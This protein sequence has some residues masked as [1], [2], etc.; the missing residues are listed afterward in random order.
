MS[1][2]TIADVRKNAK[3]ARIKLYDGEAEHFH[4]ELSNILNWVEQLSEVDTSN[5]EPQLSG[6]KIHAPMAEDVV[7]DGGIKEQ[8]LSNAPNKKMGFYVVPKVVE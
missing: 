3:L 5:V 6:V 7:Q 2:I 4:D 8:V 1:S